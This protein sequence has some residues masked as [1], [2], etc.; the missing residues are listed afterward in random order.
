M[1][2]TL[3]HTIQFSKKNEINV[4]KEIKLQ[5]C[6]VNRVA[7]KGEK[8]FICGRKKDRKQHGCIKQENAKVFEVDA[9][10]G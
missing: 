9:I 7:N 2:D 1:L 4:A 10:L 6:K 5:F 8:A 3:I